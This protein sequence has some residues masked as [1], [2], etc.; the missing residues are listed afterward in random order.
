VVSAEREGL[1][2][3]PK[4]KSFICCIRGSLRAASFFNFLYYLSAKYDSLYNLNLLYINIEL[5]FKVVELS[6][7][8]GGY[9]GANRLS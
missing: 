6:N 1:R 9:N 3:V 2:R 4:G 7:S 5:L 8:E